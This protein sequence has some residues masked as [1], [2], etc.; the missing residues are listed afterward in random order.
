MKGINPGGILTRFSQVQSPT[1]YHLSCT[2]NFERVTHLG[3]FVWRRS[4]WW[5][6]RSSACTTTA[7]ASTTWGPRSCWRSSS[8]GRC[9]KRGSTSWSPPRLAPWQRIVSVTSLARCLSDRPSEERCQCENW[10]HRFEPRQFERIHMRRSL[11]EWP[12]VLRCLK[13]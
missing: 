1:L 11:D 9:R 8:W 4:S 13:A 12:S 2:H 10:W 5:V 3:W 7:R 6:H